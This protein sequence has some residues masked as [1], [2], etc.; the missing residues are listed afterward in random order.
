M[1]L[2]PVGPEVATAM[3]FYP[4][5]SV[6]DVLRA[7][8]EYVARAPDEVTTI[9]FLSS[10]VDHPAIPD[11]THHDLSLGVMACYV[12][13]V[14]DGEAA[15]APLRELAGVAPLSDHGKV[16]TFVEF[17]DSDD[18][19][20]HGRHYYWKS[21]YLDDLD[22]DAIQAL[23]DHA[24]HSP[25]HLSS[26]TLWGFGGAMTRVPED[27]TA[28]AGRDAAFMLTVEASWEDAED[29]AETVAWARET[30]A[31]LCERSSGGL[32]VNFPGLRE[33]GRN[34]V[35]AASGDNY[36]RLVETCER[37]DPDG[38]F[39]LNRDLLAAGDD[40]DTSPVGS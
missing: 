1:N 23:V 37:Y 36:D 3:V 11:G 29:T 35:R 26:L 16:T 6:A 34:L 22:D 38:V 39:A 33:E 5:E 12:G 30:W 24:D 13:P 20:P 40:G 10:T 27:E 4:G 7:Y 2:H 17:H 15:L 8:R 14:E 32:Y 21:L 25:S 28:F 18:V 19:Y 31:D 9:A